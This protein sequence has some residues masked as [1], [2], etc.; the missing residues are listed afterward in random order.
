MSL[1]KQW[2][3]DILL[4]I[5]NQEMTKVAKEV[6]QYEKGKWVLILLSMLMKIYC[7][8]NNSQFFDDYLIQISTVKR[9]DKPR[10]KSVVYIGL[11]Y[12]SAINKMNLI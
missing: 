10:L 6:F 8:E 5:T 1:V 2:M 7:V 4:E 9:M 12:L 11:Y 3:T